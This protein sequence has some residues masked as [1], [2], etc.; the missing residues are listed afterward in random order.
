M[1]R[2]LTN[3]LARAFNRRIGRAMITAAAL[4]TE[5]AV[6]ITGARRAGIVPAHC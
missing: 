5:P 2:P 4:T 3:A 1:E 6:P